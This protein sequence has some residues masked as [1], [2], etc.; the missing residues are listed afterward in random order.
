MIESLEL[1]RF[2]PEERIDWFAITRF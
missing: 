2:E 1:I